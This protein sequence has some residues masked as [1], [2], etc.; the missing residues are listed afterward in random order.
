MPHAPK[1]LVSIVKVLNPERLTPLVENAASRVLLADVSLARAQLTLTPASPFLRLQIDSLSL[2]PRVL[3]S[4]PLDIREQLPTYA[5]T[6]FAVER[7]SGAVNLMSLMH[8]T[9]EFKGV[10]LFRPELNIV[11]ITD[12]LTNYDIFPSREEVDTGRVEIPEIE[13]DRF[14][15]VDPRPIRYTNI[16]EGHTSTILITSADVAGHDAPIYTIDF[17]AHIHS[18]FL[19]PYR[20]NPLRASIDGKVRWDVAHPEQVAVE[21]LKIDLAF[22]H[23]DVDGDML[24]DEGMKLNRLECKLAPV[25][26]P[27]LLK[28]IPDDIKRKYGLHRL[29]TG[30]TVA[31]EGSL[32]APYDISSGELPLFSLSLDIP[33]CEMRYG[34][35]DL[36]K[37]RLAAKLE[38][39][40]PNLDKAVV[41]IEDFYARGRN[42][43]IDV[44]MSGKFSSLIT[45]VEF[46]GK[47]N[48]NVYFGKLPPVISDLLQADIDGKMS[49]DT[50]LRLRPSQFTRNRFHKIYV[51]GDVEMSKLYYLRYDTSAM[52]YV[53][54][55]VIDFGTDKT[56]LTPDSVRTPKLLSAK[57]KVDSADILVSDISMNVIN[58][59]AGVA[60]V[61]ESYSSDTTRV[62]P[63]GASVGMDAFNLTVLTDSAKVRMRDVACKVSMRRF[64]RR[65]RV[66]EFVFNLHA[67]RMSAGSNS[68]RFM[69]S[70]MD[71][72]IRAHLDSVR[73]GRYDAFRRVVDSV[74]REHPLIPI[75]SVYV[76]A[77]ERHRR[78]PHV[79]RFSLDRNAED[80]ELINLKVARGFSR[81][82]RRW[83]FGGSVTANTARLFTPVFPL[84]NRVK[85]LKLDFTPDTLSLNNVEY[86][87]GRS[88]FLISGLVTNIRRSLLTNARVPMKIHFALESDTVDVN[89]LAKAMFSGAAYSAKADS[90]KLNL[91]YSDSDDVL[92]DSID[93]VHSDLDSVGPLLIPYNLDADLS[94]SARNVIYSDLLLHDMS[95]DVL[96]YKGAVNLNNLRASSDVGSIDLSA[97]YTAPRVSDMSFGF[98]MQTHDFNI[99]KFLK[100]VPAVDSILP[101]MRG[102][103]GII[104]AEIAAT[105]AIEPNMDIDIPS[106]KAAL[107]IHGDSL[108]LVDPETF[109]TVA[110]WLLFKNKNRNII[111]SMSV[112][113]LVEDSQL[114]VFPFSFNFDRYKLGVMGY[115]DFAMNY[116]YHIAVLKSPLPFKFEKR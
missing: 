7:F 95:G 8:G 81:F 40:S 104:D 60:T 65:N 35:F 61:N 18:P 84:R 4:L 76:L 115:N 20:V 105:C 93:R 48:G 54:H 25:A 2:H 108:T 16:A 110:K 22:L 68:V 23:L 67:G 38:F 59:R 44:S 85:N 39:A 26:M 1:L 45:D 113:M 96:A 114:R 30:A 70:G 41:E 69:L 112:E 14:R 6:L 36:S 64:Q 74:S 89:Q 5:D 27:D 98:G 3:D 72:D 31:I 33:E 77:L 51:E 46:N 87:V 103:G 106:M 53:D 91:S 52:V 13:F 9:L 21:G 19:D 37:L 34:G 12:K 58:L 100:L 62:N 116:D 49:F 63:I 102:L 83:D 86:K 75:D 17:G 71:A 90:L 55:G 92:Q 94:V 28:C 56:L 99:E 107:R 78:K 47:V 57:L 80:E 11:D 82:L 43:G 29:H 66:P 101:L 109:K 88:D 24:F 32:L 10:E 73:A 97:L 15:L 42:G 79:R 111:D 50:R